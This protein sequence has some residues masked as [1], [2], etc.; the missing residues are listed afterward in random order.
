M[1]S[2]VSQRFS[3]R[4]GESAGRKASACSFAPRSSLFYI[5]HNK[6][7]LQKFFTVLSVKKDHKQIVH[8][9][10]LAISFVCC[11]SHDCQK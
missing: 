2:Q 8:T 9:T 11:Y 4:G 7:F 10:L 5:Q 1:H 3:P 6:K